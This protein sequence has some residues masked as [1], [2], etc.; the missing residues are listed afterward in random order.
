MLVTLFTDIAN[1]STIAYHSRMET[2]Y[3][4]KHHLYTNNMI[5][6]FE[7]SDWVIPGGGLYVG[8]R[9]RCYEVDVLDDVNVL[10]VTPLC[11]DLF[12]PTCHLRII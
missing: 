10:H 3:H 7:S 1:Y 2:A 9:D 6:M 5:Y 12:K 8:G 11:E 4:R